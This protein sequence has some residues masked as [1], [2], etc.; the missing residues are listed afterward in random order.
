ML[1]GA[2]LRCPHLHSMAV[3][4]GV[5]AAVPAVPTANYCGH[6]FM[7]LCERQGRRLHAKHAAAHCHALRYIWSCAVYS[8]V[9]R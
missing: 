6:I 9:L 4:V 7:T 3:T 2:R 5:R 8:V 1:S